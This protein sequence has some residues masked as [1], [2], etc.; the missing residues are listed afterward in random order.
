M[1]TLA[2][3]CILLALALVTPDKTESVVKPNGDIMIADKEQMRTEMPK[4][5]PDSKVE[6]AVAEKADPTEAPAA[7]AAPAATEAPEPAAEETAEGGGDVDTGES[8]LEK[9]IR[10]YMSCKDTDG[11]TNGMS[12]LDA[13]TLEHYQETEADMEKET[14]SGTKLYIEGE[15]LTCGAY[16]FHEICVNPHIISKEAVNLPCVMEDRMQG[17]D[18]NNPEENCCG[19]GKSRIKE[20]KTCTESTIAFIKGNKEEVEEAVFK[21]LEGDAATSFLVLIAAIPAFW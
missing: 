4:A 18:F 15:G 6:K 20:R 2:N 3:C 16:V 9:E 12:K 11:W 1:R 17:A 14:H 13:D 5:G 8:E 21:G 10:L 19:C 7:E